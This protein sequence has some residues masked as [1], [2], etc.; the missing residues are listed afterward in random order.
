MLGK[1]NTPQTLFG[2]ILS[3][4]GVLFTLWL[5]NMAMENCPFIDGLPIKKGDVPW[6]C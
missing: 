6:L 5:F 2:C 3:C 4:L 1:R